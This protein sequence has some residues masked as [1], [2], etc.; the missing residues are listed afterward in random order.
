MVIFLNLDG[1]CQKITPEH[2]YQGSNNVTD[3]TVV[4]PFSPDTAM[5]IGFILPNGRY[6]TNDDGVRYMPMEF[7]EQSVNQNVSAWH[8]A[9]PDSVTAVMGDLYIAFNAVTITGNT[10]SYMC[11]VQIEESVLPNDAPPPD[12]SVYDYLKMYLARLDGRTKNVPN[13]VARI[14]KVKGSNNAFTYTDN[15]GV[16]S[17]EIILGDPYAAPIPVNAASAIKIPGKA[18][19]PT[20]AED[21]T[22]VTGYTY[23]LTSAMHGQ[24][25]DGATAK[26][27]WVSFDEAVT[28]GLKGATGDYTV[29]ESGDITITVNQPVAMTVRVWNGKGLVDKVARDDI[30]A[31]TQRAEQAEQAIRTDMNAADSNLQEQINELVN[32]GIDT[33]ARAAIA[34]ETERAESAESELQ[35]DLNTAQEQL[36]GQINTIDSYI[37]SST[38]TENQLAD[39]AFVNSSINNMA[40]F[41][42]TSNA[43]GAAFSTQASLLNATTYY[44]GGQP[45]TPTQNDYAI[46]LADESQPKNVDGKY[47]TTRYS[48]QGSEWSFQYVVNNTPL[49]QDQ[50]NAINSGITKEIVTQITKGNVIGVKGSTETTY[51]TGNVNLTPE[52]IGALPTSGGTVTGNLTVA[53]NTTVTNPSINASSDYEALHIYGFAPSNVAGQKSDINFYGNG[54]LSK[55]GTISCAGTSTGTMEYKSANHNIVG[56]TSIYNG[57]NSTYIELGKKTATG[58]EF[59]CQQGNANLDY[60]AYIKAMNASSS[61]EVGSAELY[62]DARNH[63]F[64]GRVYSEN[65]AFYSHGNELNFLYNY[66]GNPDVYINYRDSRTLINTYRFYNGLGSA[67]RTLRKPSLTTGTVSPNSVLS[68]EQIDQTL[69]VVTV[70]ATESSEYGTLGIRVGSSGGLRIAYTEGEHKYWG[71]ATLCVTAVLAGQQDIYIEGSNIGRVNYSIMYF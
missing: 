4:A 58:L 8:F 16:V 45:R 7:A 59:H 70:W 34:A 66:S 22:T 3:I 24:M 55:I 11:K 69:K 41:Y 27:L 51:R 6:W 52:N 64:Q 38:T 56:K 40:A 60:D 46:V 50:V 28:G 42:I 13:L 25:R 47:P 30:A 2:I 5:G 44:Y 68:S 26:D 23:L 53:G 21:N 17:D 31:E 29:N 37:P 48:Y 63:V 10:T 62:Y 49:T 54:G 1:S 33:V 9:L 35:Q 32:T 12:M 20:Y 15:S 14:Q 18:W 65:N 36:Q 39:K 61:T 19:Q 67:V 71:A 43:A 57:T